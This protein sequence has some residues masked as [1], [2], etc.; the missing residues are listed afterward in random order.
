MAISEDWLVALRAHGN[1]A[2]EQT[3]GGF[4][5]EALSSVMN[6]AIDDYGEDSRSELSGYSSMSSFTGSF[7]GSAGA[8]R[9]RRS[10]V[11]V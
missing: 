1:V 6:S 8:N 10:S 2:D 9:R 5:S 4:D 3:L 11:K 7:G